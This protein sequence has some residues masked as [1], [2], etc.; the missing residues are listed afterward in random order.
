MAASRGQQLKTGSKFIDL[1]PPTP[2][3][4]HSDATAKSHG[5]RWND[6]SSQWYGCGDGRKNGRRGYPRGG[7][8]E[9]EG[10]DV[11]GQGYTASSESPKWPVISARPGRP[12]VVNDR[13]HVTDCCVAAGLGSRRLGGPSVTRDR[14]VAATSARPGRLA[15]SS[16]RWRVDSGGRRKTWRRWRN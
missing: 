8:C 14:R 16:R 12:E 10:V 3:S 13:S 9:L 1:D 2:G 7:V 15:L 5:Q 6:F 4:S 11:P